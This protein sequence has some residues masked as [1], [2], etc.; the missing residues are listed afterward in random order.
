M[1]RAI[2]SP[3]RR[4]APEPAVGVD[5]QQRDALRQYRVVGKLSRFQ[6]RDIERRT[7]WNAADRY[8]WPSARSPRSQRSQLARRRDG[9]V[10]QPN[11]RYEPLDIGSSEA[12]D[13]TCAT[14]APLE[15]EQFATGA[16]AADLI[17]LAAQT[18]PVPP[19]SSCCTRAERP[20]RPAS[21]IATRRK[22][23]EQV[24]SPMQS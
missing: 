20:K 10:A 4:T 12:A 6:L 9:T 19:I 14:S 16:Y 3:I 11:R 18:P 13:R 2:L 8:R 1:P 7:R 22:L 17:R 23:R 15:S 5:P 21:V 24:I